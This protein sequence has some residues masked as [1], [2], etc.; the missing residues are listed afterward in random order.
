MPML[1][2]K[3]I[4]KSLILQAVLIFLFVFIASVLLWIPIRNSYCYV[5]TV[6][7]SKFL[8]AV[9]NAA[10]ED[11]VRTG[12]S[13]SVTMGFYKGN[14]YVSAAIP[15]S[16]SFSRTYDFA[17]PLTSALFAS[18]IPFIKRKKR[19][20]AEAFLLLFFS[21]FLYIFFTEATALTARLMLNGIE[22]ATSPWLSFYQYSWS[23]MKYTAMSFGPF[24]I[25][26]YVFIR[27]RK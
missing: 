20:F 25:T 1:H 14:K 19:A 23:I 24:L 9:K 16:D 22:P 27:F 13:I 15:L 12:N 17:V 18:L 10:W 6:V 11:V 26:I 3:L 7:A 4:P 21:H 2:K 8:A 5:I